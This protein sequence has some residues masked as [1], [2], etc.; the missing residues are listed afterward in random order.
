[1]DPILDKYQAITGWNP[2]SI[3]HILRK[4]IRN[5]NSE[6]AF[7]DFLRRE[8]EQELNEQENFDV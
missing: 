7:E 2:H 1:V 3:I 8:A 4:Y 6:D 5:Q